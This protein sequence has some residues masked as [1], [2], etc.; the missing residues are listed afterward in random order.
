MHV[1]YCENS[2]TPHSPHIHSWVFTVHVM[3]LQV[4]LVLTK[5][6]N[7]HFTVGK[8]LASVWVLS[9]IIYWASG[10]LKEVTQKDSQHSRE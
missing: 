10:S 7:V 4:W 5:I 9:A 3:K 6:L 8:Y 2:P 1:S